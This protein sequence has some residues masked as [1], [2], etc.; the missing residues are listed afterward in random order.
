M[1]R[2]FLA[3]LL[4]LPAVT[5][6]EPRVAAAG[7]DAGRPPAAD[8]AA[9]RRCHR[10]LSGAFGAGSHG[11]GAIGCLDCHAGAEEHA[12]ALGRTPAPDPRTY[13]LPR[14]QALC[15]DCHQPDSAAFRSQHA[16][17]SR[18]A[19][20]CLECHRFHEVTAALA[21]PPAPRRSHGRA[22]PPPPAGRHLGME[23]TRGFLEAGVRG[24][25]GGSRAFRTQSDREPGPRLVHLEQA[26]QARA[27]GAGGVDH[28]ELHLAGLGDPAT[29][30]SLALGRTGKWTL[31]F[32]GDR[33]EDLF[34]PTAEIHDAFTIRAALGADLEWRTRAGTE[35]AVGY[36]RSERRE[37]AR[38]TRFRDVTNDRLDPVEG[39]PAEAADLLRF[40]ADGGADP[41]RLQNKTS[42]RWWRLSDS[43]DFLSPNPLLDDLED[44]DS[45]SRALT[46]ASP[47]AGGRA[48]SPPAIPPRGSGPV[49]G[50]SWASTPT[51]VRRTS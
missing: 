36:Q 27:G 44:F 17:E 37:D 45:R 29:R 30:G 22:V 43:R 46:G 51:G 13:P 24:L 7:A 4:L 34:D 23:T 38:L 40:R 31:R 42:L 26:G 14:A 8:V 1:K 16:G 25:D 2:V 19:R 49:A 48:P 35:L 9:C 12:A 10:A 18:L 3:S 50:T 33:H 20:S 21:A 28:Y 5:L 32:S 15:T 47:C 6:R 39:D 11:T 41:W